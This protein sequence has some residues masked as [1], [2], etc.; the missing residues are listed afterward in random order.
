[1]NLTHN[2]ILINT[3]EILCTKQH[4]YTHSN[5]IYAAAT[6][7]TRQ[8]PYKKIRHNS[9]PI[10]TTA[11]LIHTTA[12]LYKQQQPYIH[13]SNLMHTTAQH[14]VHTTATLYT[15]QQ[16]CSHNSNPIHK[17]I[18]PVYKAAPLNLPPCHLCLFCSKIFR[19][20]VGCDDVMEKPV[21]L[22]LRR[23]CNNI[24]WLYKF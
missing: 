12:T 24:S 2:S 21:F 8:Q 14:P 1:M 15:Q 18:N 7:C 9:N 6:L 19:L 3:T 22:L 23:D 16:P 11:T 20:E 10:Y 5:F 13:N 17:T 4:P